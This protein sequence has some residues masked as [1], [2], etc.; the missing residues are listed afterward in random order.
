MSSGLSLNLQMDKGL[1]TIKTEESRI[2]IV[3]L[4]F[5]IERLQMQ[6]QKLRKQLFNAFEKN[7]NLGVLLRN[8]DVFQTTRLHFFRI[9]ICD[10]ICVSVKDATHHL[11]AIRV[12][13][14]DER[15]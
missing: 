6:V 12:S 3:L 7:E 8:L 1:I 9:R 10:L 4:L 2:S 13:F 11:T 14:Q 15:D 5:L